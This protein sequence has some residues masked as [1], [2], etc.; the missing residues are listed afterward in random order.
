M[1]A[2]AVAA[3]AAAAAADDDDDDDDDDEEVDWVQDEDD[4]RFF[5]MRCGSKKNPYQLVFSNVK[6][7]SYHHSPTISPWQ[8]DIQN[9]VSLGILIRLCVTLSRLASNVVRNMGFQSRQRPHA[10]MLT[11]TRLKSF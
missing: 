1:V 9:S 11:C 5:L 8:R 7:K 2:V 10:C 4:E 3:A 6:V